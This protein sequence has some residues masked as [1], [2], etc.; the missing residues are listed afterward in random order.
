MASSTS[1][2]ATS[3]P[4][5]LWPLRLPDTSA[6]PPGPCTASAR[7]VYCLIGAGVYCIS[8]MCTAAARC[9]HCIRQVCVLPQAGVYCISQWKKGGL[10]HGQG[11]A[12]GQVDCTVS[13]DAAAPCP[14][15]HLP[16]SLSVKG[17]KRERGGKEERGMMNSIICRCRSEV[18]LATDWALVRRGGRS[19]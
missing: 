4:Q 11:P 14:S 17:L 16:P 1:A 7:C 5:F 10:L 15:P 9:V 6:G 18:N 19:T 3:T 2:A 8:Q 12:R 13:A